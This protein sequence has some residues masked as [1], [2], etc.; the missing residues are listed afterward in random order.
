M[1]I[2]QLKKIISNLPDET[3][4]L[5]DADDTYYVQTAMVEHHSDGRIYLLLSNAE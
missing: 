1:T 2:E 5:I 4:I 3:P